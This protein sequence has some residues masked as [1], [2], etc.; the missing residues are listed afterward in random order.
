MIY[1]KSVKTVKVFSHV[2]F[3]HLQYSNLSAVQLL[4]SITT[5]AVAISMVLNGHCIELR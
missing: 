1:R 5:Y 3:C 2:T 4:S